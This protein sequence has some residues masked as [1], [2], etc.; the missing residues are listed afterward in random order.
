MKDDESYID[1]TRQT[2]VPIEELDSIVNNPEGLTIEGV[3]FNIA[4]Y[5]APKGTG[6][7]KKG[8]NKYIRGKY[9]LMLKKCKNFAKSGKLEDGRTILSR[10]EKGNV[11]WAEMIDDNFQLVKDVVLSRIAGV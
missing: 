3:K 9:E 4:S 2:V 1:F 8:G 7:G 6:R 11:T 5:P 10:D